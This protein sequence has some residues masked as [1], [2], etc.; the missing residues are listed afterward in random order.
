MCDAIWKMRTYPKDDGMVKVVEEDIKVRTQV[1][2]FLRRRLGEVF[3]VFCVERGRD[4]SK[5]PTDCETWG[6]ENEV[7]C[8][9]N[10]SQVSLLELIVSKH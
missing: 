3:V 6:E 4:S 5:H 1:I 10:G 9:G 2:L 8:L 7:E